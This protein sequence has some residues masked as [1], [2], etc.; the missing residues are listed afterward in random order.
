MK[1]IIVVLVLFS[2]VLSA[3]SPTAPAPATTEAAQAPLP[4]QEEAAQP[5]AAP[6]QAPTETSAPTPLPPTPTT[7]P[8]EEPTATA[9]YTPDANLPSLGDLL[10]SPNAISGAENIGQFA[11]ELA[12]TRFL[13][14][15]QD[16]GP[17]TVFTPLNGFATGEGFK[18]A[19]EAHVVPGLY[20]QADLLAMDGQSLTTSVEGKTIA[21]T[22]K[23]G[24]VYLNGLAV[25]LKADILA[26]NGVIHVIDQFLL[27]PGE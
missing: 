10:F 9:A 19:V 20:R 25:I 12:Q 1:K 13:I 5:K 21:I 23:D 3:C 17:F 22:V 2:L 27:P 18:E 4:T 15:F 26:R 6:T 14:L 24:V 16:D 7:E 8:T 11:G